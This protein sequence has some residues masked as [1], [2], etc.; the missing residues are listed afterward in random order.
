[1]SADILTFSSR[2]S[3]SSAMR[4]PW[5]TW[6][7]ADSINNSAEEYLPTTKSRRSVAM[8][9]RIVSMLILALHNWLFLRAQESVSKT[10]CTAQFP[11]MLLRD[12]NTAD[13]HQRL[14]SSPLALLEQHRHLVNRRAQL[15]SYEGICTFGF[16][17]FFFFFVAVTLCHCYNWVYVLFCGECYLALW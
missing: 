9:W 2:I 4:W 5:S 8:R 1:M 3:T 14:F 11:V 7:L 6:I 16:V 10:A 17:C 13:S 12:Q 15:Y